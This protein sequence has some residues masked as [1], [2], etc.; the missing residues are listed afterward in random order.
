MELKNRKKG[1]H[2]PHCKSRLTYNL[3]WTGSMWPDFLPAHK[4][5]VLHCSECSHCRIFF[6]SP[7]DVPK[8]AEAITHTT[9]GEDYIQSKTHPSKGLIR[10]PDAESNWWIWGS[11]PGYGNQIGMGIGILCNQG[12]G[13]FF[14]IDSDNHIRLRQAMV[15]MNSRQTR[16]EF[17]AL[18][19]PVQPSHSTRPASSRIRSPDRSSKL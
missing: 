10:F 17:L 12:M 5:Y 2:C 8:G 7:K 14:P 1:A 3:E 16:A 13:F 19:S 9:L 15:L 4:I 11:A 18:S 6:I